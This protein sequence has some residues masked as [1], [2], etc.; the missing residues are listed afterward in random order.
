MDE[1]KGV[2]TAIRKTKTK[3][4]CIYID[5][6]KQ[7]PHYMRFGRQKHIYGVLNDTLEETLP[8]SGVI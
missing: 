2:S 6:T 7:M 1:R 5:K 4:A 8:H 3:T